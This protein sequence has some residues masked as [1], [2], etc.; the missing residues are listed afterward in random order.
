MSR[1]IA[2]ADA[3]ATDIVVLPGLTGMDEFNPPEDD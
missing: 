3:R 1:R 2:N